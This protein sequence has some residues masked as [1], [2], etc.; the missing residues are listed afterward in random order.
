MANSTRSNATNERNPSNKI[1]EEL[2]AVRLEDAMLCANCEVIVSEMLRGRCPVCGSSALLG[3]SRLLGST[4]HR[5]SSRPFLQ[6]Q[7]VSGDGLEARAS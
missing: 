2:N 3:L 1:F 5:A 7:R 6:R 4:L